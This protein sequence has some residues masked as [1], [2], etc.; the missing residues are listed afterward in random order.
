MSLSSKYRIIRDWLFRRDSNH[1]IAFATVVAAFAAVFYTGYAAGQLRIMKGQLNEMR[2]GN[3]PWIGINPDNGLNVSTINIDGQGTAS[4]T[5]SM[6]LKN[7]GSYPGKNVVA[8]AWLMIIHDEEY[9]AVKDKMD[10]TCVGGPTYGAAIFPSATL[11]REWDSKVTDA[12]KVRSKKHPDNPI[13]VAYIVGCVAYQEQSGSQHHTGFAYRDQ[14]VG[15]NQAMTFS[16][17]PNRTVPQGEWIQ[18]FSSVD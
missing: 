15:K 6:T 12:D 8:L 5:M 14:L 1:V 11:T 10:S 13:F 4:L 9:T 3:R 2:G 16:T 17:F 7:F 18:W